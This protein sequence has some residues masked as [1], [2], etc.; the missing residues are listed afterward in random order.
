MILSALVDRDKLQPCHRERLAEL[1]TLLTPLVS[2]QQPRLVGEPRFRAM[3]LVRRLARGEDEFGKT[4]Y[5]LRDGAI[6]A[7]YAYAD[8]VAKLFDAAVGDNAAA[9]AA[10]R[11]TLACVFHHLNVQVCEHDPSSFPFPFAPPKVKRGRE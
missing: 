3:E 9:H 2:L 8:G 11:H 5:E 6:Q 10:T 7:T 1:D 4:D